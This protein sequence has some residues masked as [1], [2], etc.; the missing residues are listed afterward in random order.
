MQNEVQNGFGGL[1]K[2]SMISGRNGRIRTC[3][4]LT[5]SQLYCPQKSNDLRLISHW[6]CK[7][8]RADA[9]KGTATSALSAKRPT[10]KDPAMR[11]GTGR[12]EEK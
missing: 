12:W 5:P 11:E 2:T 10:P 6:D 1:G 3:D 8:M 4:P 9:P 7:M